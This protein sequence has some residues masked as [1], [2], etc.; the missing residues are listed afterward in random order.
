M[1]A[2]LGG[3]N[4][5]R[6]RVARLLTEQ[7]PVAAHGVVNPLARSA[8]QSVAVW[9]VTTGLPDRA[10]AAPRFQRCAALCH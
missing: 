4:L 3:G 7:T 9:L 10:R 5:T 1:R 2:T 6:R 8:C